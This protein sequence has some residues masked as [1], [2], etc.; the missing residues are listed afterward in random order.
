MVVFG[1]KPPRFEQQAGVVGFGF[2]G[3]LKIVPRRAEI[4]FVPFLQRIGQMNQRGFVLRQFCVAGGELPHFVPLPRVEGVVNRTFQFFRRIADLVDFTI[5]RNIAV[6]F[7]HFLA[8]LFRVQPVTFSILLRLAA[9]LIQQAAAF[10]RGI[11][12]RGG[13]ADRTERQEKQAEAVFHEIGS[14]GRRGRLKEVKQK[15]CEIMQVCTALQK[16][17]SRSI[18]MPTAAVVKKWRFT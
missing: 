16:Q 14:L 11:V 3:R 17:V 5:Y 4:P 6:V 8:G 13:K 9:A 1:I 12:G 7:F 18:F 10:V 15:F 2:Q